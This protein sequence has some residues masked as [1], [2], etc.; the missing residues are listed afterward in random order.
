MSQLYSIND[1]ALRAGGAAARATGKPG[2]D[3]PA[4]RQR[5]GERTIALPGHE[6]HVLALD[7]NPCPTPSPS[8]C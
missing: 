6:F 1:K 8:R 2:A 5:R 3:A 7:G 4:K